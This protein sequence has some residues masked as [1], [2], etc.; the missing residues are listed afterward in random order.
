MAQ[1]RWTKGVEAYAK[2]CFFVLILKEKS[3]RTFPKKHLLKALG[4]PDIRSYFLKLCIEYDDSK[5]LKRF[6]QG[7]LLSVQALGATLVSKNTGLDRVNLYRMLKTGGNPSFIAI[8]T[9]C[10]YLGAHL[11]VVDDDFMKRKEKLHRPKEEPKQ[12]RI[13]EFD[14]W[15]MP[16]GTRQVGVKNYRRPK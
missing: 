6:K 12:Y 15:S 13:P 14:E 7:L 3:T 4:D 5:D 11:W 16:Y 10:R 1:G 2:E 9:L 8:N